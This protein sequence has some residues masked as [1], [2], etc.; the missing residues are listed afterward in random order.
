[1]PVLHP[2]CALRPTA[3][4]AREVVCLPYDVL[5]R[6]EAADQA[7]LA[8]AQTHAGQE[9]QPGQ[10]NSFLRVTRAEIDL[11]DLADQHDPQ[12]HEQAAATLSAFISRGVLVAEDTPTLYL[13]RETW[14]SHQQ[15]GVVGCVNVADYDNGTIKQ[16]E[17]TLAVKEADRIAHFDRVNAHT[18]PVFLTYPAQ[19]RINTLLAPVLEQEP[20]FKVATVDDTT[21]ELWAL[22]QTLSD[23]VSELFAQLPAFYIADGHHRS[24]SAAKVGRTRPTEQSGEADRFLAVVIPDSDLTCL[25]YNRLVKDWGDSNQE[26]FLARLDQVCELSRCWD[27]EPV[28]SAPGQFACYFAGNWWHCTFRDQVPTEQAQANPTSVLDVARLQDLVLNPLLGVGDP[29]TDQRIDFVGGIK[30]NQ[31]LAQAVDSGQAVIAFA[32]YPTQ[33]SQVLQIADA[34]LIMPPKSTWFEPKLASGLFIHQL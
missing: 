26:D 1:M 22:G 7:Q 19:A 30:G 32:M 18:E 12:V 10:G 9:R 29:R 13:Y 33:I 16:H 17:R 15:V 2:F 20:L 4:S 24:A 28:L 14:R 6:E 5:S 25:P 27:Q 3:Q 11:P 31:A 21:H 23:Q 34:G 8:Y